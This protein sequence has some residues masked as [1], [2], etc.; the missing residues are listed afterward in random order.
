MNK[1]YIKN[2]DILA[3]TLAI[4]VRTHQ[5]SLAKCYKQGKAY[6][7]NITCRVENTTV[8]PK[9]KRWR[10]KNDKLPALDLYQ[11]IRRLTTWAKPH[12]SK[13]QPAARYSYPLLTQIELDLAQVKFPPFASLTLF[14]FHLLQFLTILSEID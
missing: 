11:L 5:S 4:K 14:V 3:F 10:I 12:Q 8:M 6:V 2:Q 7:Q 1:Y 13:T 9:Q